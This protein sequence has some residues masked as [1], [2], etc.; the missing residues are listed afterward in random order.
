MNYANIR[1]FYNE[2]QDEESRHIFRSRVEYLFTGDREILRDMTETVNKTFHPAI[3]IRNVSALPNSVSPDTEV[4]IFSVGEFSELCCLMLREKGFHVRA[5]CDPRHKSFQ[6]GYLGAPV[7]SS[8]TLAADAIYRKC[9]VVFSNPVWQQ[10]NCELLI[11]KGFRPGNLFVYEGEYR[12]T[13]Y[14]HRPGY[15]EQEFFAFSDGEVYADVGCL[16][17]DTIRQF[18]RACS[19]RYAKIFGFEP[20]PAS[21]RAT[22]DN[23]AKWG[24]GDAV[25]I[26]KGAWSSESELRFTSE[27]G[28][29]AGAG[30]A[31]IANFGEI[32]VPTTT[33]DNA[34]KDE[35]VTFIKMDIEGAELEALKGAEGLLK[36]QKPRLAVCLYHK[37]EDIVEIPE[38]LYRAGPDY[39]FYIRHHNYI[40]ENG[41]YA[42]DTVL[43]AV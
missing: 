42:H 11:S 28:A 25:V 8:D 20:N 23:L 7:I 15:F 22:V 9:A 29:D 34:L 31:R 30:G 38:F 35:P 4:V 14:A 1:A 39:R 40:R 21:Y 24:L 6:G 10:V 18:S 2:L 37:P 41:N 5:F 26:P 12:F 19:G 36:K 32:T 16:D 27:Y 3:I 33:L 17:G 43:Y 13:N